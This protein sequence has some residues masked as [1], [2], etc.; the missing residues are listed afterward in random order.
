MKNVTIFY[1]LSALLSNLT[2]Y[3]VMNKDVDIK[4]YLKMNY[5]L[6]SDC[7]CAKYCNYKKYLDWIKELEKLLD[8]KICRIETK[9]GGIFKGFCAVPA[10]AVSTDIK[11][12]I[13]Y[14]PI[15]TGI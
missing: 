7:N 4:R 1:N 2:V 6:V 12:T 9:G 15:I 8:K 3:A 10:D 5:S 14:I 13:R 11:S